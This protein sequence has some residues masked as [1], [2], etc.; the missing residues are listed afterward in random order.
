ML[1]HDETF[2]GGEARHAIERR[3]EG[4]ERIAEGGA[5][6]RVGKPR[7]T[8][9]EHREVIEAQAERRLGERAVVDER[10]ATQGQLALGRVGIRREEPA[11]GDQPEDRVTEKLEPLVR[12]LGESLAH[13]ALVRERGLERGEIRVAQPARV[14]ERSHSPATRLSAH[15]PT[16]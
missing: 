8:D 15:E 12:S 6:A 7:E 4:L 10:G 1:V 3:D 2:G 9:T 11:R 13:R 14:Q 16:Y 5:L